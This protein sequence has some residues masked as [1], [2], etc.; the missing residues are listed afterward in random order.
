[1]WLLENIVWAK[2]FEEAHDKTP[3]REAIQ[4]EVGS[5][6]LCGRLPSPIFTTLHCVWPRISHI[7]HLS[8]PPLY[9]SLPACSQG[10]PSLVKNFFFPEKRFAA[11]PY[12][13]RLG[14]R[15]SDF[16]AG[17]IIFYASSP[18][19]ASFSN[20][21]VHSFVHRFQRSGRNTRSGKL[22]PHFESTMFT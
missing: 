6:I 18:F 17:C 21:P 20:H 3:W 2:H 5:G 19:F 10:H 15:I 16:S 14:S 12:F 4:E 11:H 8:S 1:M 7:W 13:T 9:P 22:S